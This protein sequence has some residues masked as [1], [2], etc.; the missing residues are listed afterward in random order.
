LDVFFKDGLRSILSLLED[1]EWFLFVFGEPRGLF[2][3][4]QKWF[5]LLMR[6]VGVSPDGTEGVSGWGREGGRKEGG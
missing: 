5:L 2:F 6:G 3:K 4:A 1:Q